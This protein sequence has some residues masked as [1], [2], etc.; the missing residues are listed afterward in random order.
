MRDGSAGA[1]NYA[2]LVEY[3]ELA[4]QTQLAAQTGIGG[5]AINKAPACSLTQPGLCFRK[6]TSTL[7]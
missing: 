5:A 7:G 6:S 1:H 4:A 2:S 3:S